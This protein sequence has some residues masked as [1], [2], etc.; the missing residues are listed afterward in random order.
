MLLYVQVFV[1]TEVFISCGY[2]HRGG[3]ARSYVNCVNYLRNCQIIFRSGYILLHSHQQRMKVPISP[4]SSL[5]FSLNN[6]LFA[7][8]GG[9]GEEGNTPRS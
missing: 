2:I 4:H 8:N 5:D 9:T 6:S 7:K 3:I 1:W